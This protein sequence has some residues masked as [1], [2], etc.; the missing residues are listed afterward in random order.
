MSTG[1][2]LWKKWD[3]LLRF[4]GWEGEDARKLG[5]LYMAVVQAVLLFESETWVMYPQIGRKMG[6][7]HL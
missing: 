5:T 3:R 7:F 2:I 1:K 4:L 6:G